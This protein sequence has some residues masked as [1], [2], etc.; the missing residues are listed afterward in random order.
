MKKTTAFLILI[1]LKTIF[2]AQDIEAYK[3]SRIE[4]KFI[5]KKN[6]IKIFPGQRISIST[7]NKKGVLEG[8]NLIDT[9]KSKIIK[10]EEISTLLIKQNAEKNIVIDFN[11]VKGEGGK[12]TAVLIVNNPYNQELSY[13]AKVFSN[14]INDYEETSINPVL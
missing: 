1:F 6:T 4:N 9:S 5:Y 11:V 10:F 3:A 14:K 8:I 2:F 12:L 13:K 7:K